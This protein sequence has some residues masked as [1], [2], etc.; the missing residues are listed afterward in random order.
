MLLIDNTVW[1]N[2][3]IH[4]GFDAQMFCQLLLSHCSV[5]QKSHYDQIRHILSKTVIVLDI[6]L[7]LF[8]RQAKALFSPGSDT[9]DTVL[10]FVT[11]ETNS[12][13]H[14]R[15]GH[16]CTTCAVVCMVTCVL[17]VSDIPQY[18]SIHFLFLMY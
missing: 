10:R 15:F 17:I 4:G 14:L 7:L 11:M 6:C 3:I 8:K 9:I 1:C 18:T 13:G 16:V 12:V 5:L 2:G